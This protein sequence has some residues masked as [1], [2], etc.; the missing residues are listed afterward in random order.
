LDERTS[1]D[2]ALVLRM[3]ALRLETYRDRIGVL[4]AA[5]ERMEAHSDH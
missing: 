2:T 3:A 1:L 5:I 4:A